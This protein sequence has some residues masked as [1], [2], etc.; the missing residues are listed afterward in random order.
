MFDWLWKLMW[1]LKPAEGY[2][3]V[4]TAERRQRAEIKVQILRKLRKKIKN[5]R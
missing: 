5:G 3:P 4:S 2:R 1:R